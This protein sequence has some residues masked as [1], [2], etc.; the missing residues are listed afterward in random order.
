MPGLLLSLSYSRSPKDMALPT[1]GDESQ[2]CLALSPKLECSGTIMAHC[3]LYLPGSEMGSHYVAWAVL[4]LLGSSNSPISASKSD[5]ITTMKVS[6]S[7][8]EEGGT[9]E[10]GFQHAG[11][12]SLELLTLGDLPASASQSARITRT[13]PPIMWRANLGT[14]DSFAACT[15][16]TCQFALL[17]LL[18]FFVM[19]SHSLTRLVCNGT[20][21]THYNLHLS[22]SSYSPCPSLPIE[23]VLISACLGFPKCQD[24]R[25][26][27]LHLAHF[28]IIF[29]MESHT[30]AQAGV[31]WQDLGSPK[32]LPP[33]F[34]WI[35]DACHH[36]QLIFVFSVETGFCHVGQAGIELLTSGDPLSL[37][38]Q[39][40]EIT[41]TLPSHQ[42]SHLSM[43]SNR[44][45]STQGLFFLETYRKEKEDTLEQE[46][47]PYFNGKVKKKRGAEGKEIPRVSMKKIEIWKVS[48]CH[49][50]IQPEFEVAVSFDYATI[51]TVE[52]SE[53]TATSNSWA[54]GILLRDEMR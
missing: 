3:S 15:R 48:L 17:L 34:N 12:A 37:A 30:V 51:L 28:I 49:S 29:E 43:F 27:P 14:N 45:C 8:R 50:F 4:E 44:S 7:E 42:C 38:S 9:V 31:Q 2:K 22:G 52:Q 13:L 32:P 53:L 18:F 46:S 36:A 35:T 5:R 41:D 21:S 6:P 1:L 40:A 20:I 26:E 10:M 16:I 47:N 11:Q 23:M 33:G 39:S 25:R 19:E 24:Y 54:S